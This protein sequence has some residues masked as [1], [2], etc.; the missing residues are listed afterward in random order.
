MTDPR[1]I[2]HPVRVVSG[3]RLFIRQYVWPDGVSGYCVLSE[4]DEDELA[5][6]DFD[7]MPADEEIREHPAFANW[8][9]A[10]R[11]HLHV[12][13]ELGCTHCEAIDPGTWR[14]RYADPTGPS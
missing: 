10:S 5:E 13:P 1:E 4:E 2:D 12:S 6:D 8:K 7:H 11:H 9:L 14:E 3:V